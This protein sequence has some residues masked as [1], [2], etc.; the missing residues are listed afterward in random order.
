[1]NAR[2]R[3][4]AFDQSPLDDAPSEGAPSPARPRFTTP[5]EEVAYFETHDTL[6]DSKAFETLPPEQVTVHGQRRT[7]KLISL[8]IFPHQLDRIKRVAARRGMPYQTLIQLWLAE[9]L[10]EE[11]PRASGS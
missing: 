7:R 1:M 2:V 10:A 4:R 8:R 11:D 6:E 3:A 9:K 5:E